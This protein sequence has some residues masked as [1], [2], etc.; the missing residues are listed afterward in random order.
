NVISV[1]GDYE[2]AVVRLPLVKFN[3]SASE[4]KPEQKFCFSENP[5]K[6]FSFGAE[7]PK[8]VSFCF[9]QGNKGW[10]NFTVYVLFDNGDVYAMCPINVEASFQKFNEL[11]ISPPT[12]EGLQQANFIEMTEIQQKAIPLALKGKD[13]LGAA[14]T[15]SGKT[16]AFLIPVNQTLYLF[17][18]N[19]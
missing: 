13:I 1:A 4:K 3:L 5:E 7:I 9:G 17:V 15:G 14:K 11:P 18:K 6:T 2:L 8:A 12:L 19:R 16:L 10:S